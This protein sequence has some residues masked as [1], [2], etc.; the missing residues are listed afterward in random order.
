MIFTV[1]TDIFTEFDVNIGLMAWQQWPKSNIFT[2]FY[3]TLG[4]QKFFGG[5]KIFVV[6]YTVLTDIFMEFDVNWSDGLA[7]MAKKQFF[8]QILPH[9]QGPTPKFKISRPYCASAG[10]VL[11]P[12]QVSFR[13][14]ERSRRS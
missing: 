12:C 4:L 7:A 9:P 10:K 8:Y 3:P 13:S 11:K 1:L 14:V 5:A 6:I 2:K